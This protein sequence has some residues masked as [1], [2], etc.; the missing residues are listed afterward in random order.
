MHSDG[1]NFFFFLAE[2][3]V[4]NIDICK[5]VTNVRTFRNTNELNLLLINHLNFF[6]LL[7]RKQIIDL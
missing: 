2:I 6:N 3:L 1:C 4:L 7:S 5:V